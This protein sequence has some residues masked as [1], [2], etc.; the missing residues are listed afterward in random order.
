MW[1]G[2]ESLPWFERSIRHCSF[3]LMWMSPWGLCS[4][5]WCH[6]GGWSGSKC[7]KTLDQKQRATHQEWHKSFLAGSKRSSTSETRRRDR[8]RQL[9]DLTDDDLAGFYGLVDLIS[10]AHLREADPPKNKDDE[11]GAWPAFILGCFAFLSSA[12]EDRT[13]HLFNPRMSLSQNEGDLNLPAH[14]HF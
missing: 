11:A 14:H 3:P 9:F 12:V 6:S 4:E 7:V 13:R 5:R 1:D 10:T 2:G 8:A